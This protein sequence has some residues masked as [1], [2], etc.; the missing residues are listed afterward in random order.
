MNTM[1]RPMSML[2]RRYPCDYLILQEDYIVYTVEEIEKRQQEKVQQV[3]ELLNCSYDEGIA[4]MRFFKWNWDKFMNQWF[5]SE[6]Q[7]KKKIGIVFDADLLKKNPFMSQSLQ[8]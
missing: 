8:S 1:T 7:L 5:S 6:K 4:I 3:Q 2:K